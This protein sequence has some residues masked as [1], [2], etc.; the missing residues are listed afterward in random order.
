[1]EG[2]KC[3]FLLLP[4]LIAVCFNLLTAATQK[5]R[6]LLQNGTSTSMQEV[7]ELL[8]TTKSFSLFPDR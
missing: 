3:I 2:K 5:R 4:L 1:M 7:L 8:D 6:D